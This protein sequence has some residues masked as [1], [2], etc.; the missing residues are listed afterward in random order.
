MEQKSNKNIEAK[1]DQFFDASGGR[2]FG[3]FG[4]DALAPW[5]RASRRGEERRG[6][7]RMLH[8]VSPAIVP[9]YS[10]LNCDLSTAQSLAPASRGLGPLGPRAPC[11]GGGLALPS[12]GGGG[13]SFFGFLGGPPAWLAGVRWLGVG[14]CRCRSS[15]GRRRSDVPAR[16]WLQEG[17]TIGPWARLALPL[18]RMYLLIIFLHT[19]LGRRLLYSSYIP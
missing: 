17:G 15:G 12:G 14:C 18:P 13:G 3:A 4:V 2:F 8:H 6:E 16:L 10:I 5:C 11:R 7:E 19:S 9:K 1:I